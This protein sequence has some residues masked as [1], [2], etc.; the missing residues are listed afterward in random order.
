MKTHHAARPILV[1]AIIAVVAGCAQRPPPSRLQSLA[2]VQRVTQVDTQAYEPMIVE[3]PDGT[4]FVSA[5]G[6]PLPPPPG[7]TPPAWMAKRPAGIRAFIGALRAHHMTEYDYRGFEK[8]VYF[9]WGSLT[10][11]RWSSMERRLSKLFPNFSS[12]VFEGL[13]HLNT[14]HKAEPQRVAARLTAL[15]QRGG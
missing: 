2:V 13:H 10:H 9:S 8:P 3:H 6:V 14:S 4:L 12:E 11:Q 5:P 1:V 15:W 7:G